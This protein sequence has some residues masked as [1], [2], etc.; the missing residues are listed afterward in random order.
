LDTTTITPFSPSAAASR[1]DPTSFPT[2]RSSDLAGLVTANSGLKFG[3]LTVCGLSSDTDLNGQTVR[4]V[5]AI[6][7]T[8]LGGG[9]TTD[10]ISEDHTGTR[11]HYAHFVS[12]TPSNC[13]QKHLEN[14]SC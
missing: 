8:A 5:L 14:G 7:N 1:R 9:T 4:Q 2:R 11:L 6:A 3:D 10:S 13:A 12:A